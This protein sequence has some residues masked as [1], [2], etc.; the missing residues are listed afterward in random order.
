MMLLYNYNLI[1]KT[2]PFMK[3]V[4]PQQIALPRSKCTRGMC[5]YYA[6]L[7]QMIPVIF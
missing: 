2:A 1:I 6:L 4:K 5:S 7:L 3:P